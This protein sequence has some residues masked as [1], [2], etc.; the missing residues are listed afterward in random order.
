MALNK[1]LADLG[2]YSNYIKHKRPKFVSDEWAPQWWCDEAI[3]TVTESHQLPPP[4]TSKNIDNMMRL[5]RGV[6]KTM[7]EECGGLYTLLLALVGCCAVYLPGYDVKENQE[8][9]GVLVRLENND[10]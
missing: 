4:I 10:M 1:V 8:V 9:S 3:S 5:I 6:Y 7:P 2:T